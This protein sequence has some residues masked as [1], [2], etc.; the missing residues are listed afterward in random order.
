MLTKE[1]YCKRMK[2]AVSQMRKRPTFEEVAKIVNKDAFKLDLPQR[3]YVRWEDAHARVQFDN[4]RD[5]TVEAEQ[6]RAR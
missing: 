5:A 6:T 2:V 4:S 3:T 1:V